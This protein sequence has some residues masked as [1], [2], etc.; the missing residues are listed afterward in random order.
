MILNPE[1]FILPQSEI[2]QFGQENLTYGSLTKKGLNTI[3]MNMQKYIT[4][5]IYGFDLGCGDGELIYNIEQ[6]LPDS[7]WYGVEISE[8]RISL[9]TK[10]VN[11]WQGDML[12]EN[13]RPYNVLHADNL[14]LDEIT[15]DKLEEKIEREFTGLYITYKYPEN[16]KFLKKATYLDTILTETTW[17]MHPIHL[18]FLS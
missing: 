12:F 17:M 16:I 5:N 1:L 8:H 13:F 10:N 6:L 14:C 9:Q 2:K 3:V 7:N 4:T 11:I 15:L 18:F